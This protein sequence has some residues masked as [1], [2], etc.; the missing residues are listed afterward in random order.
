VGQ[1]DPF[2]FP[3]KVV[4]TAL[5]LVSK[6][7]NC[8]S[9]LQV[10]SVGGRQRLAP[11]FVLGDPR[12]LQLIPKRRN[13]VLKLANLALGFRRFHDLPSLF[14]N[15]PDLSNVPGEGYPLLS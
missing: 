1:L 10:L 6:G 14:Q 12:F 8:R 4:L 15:V 5:Q 11:A 2:H 13:H 7:N 9:K 3:F